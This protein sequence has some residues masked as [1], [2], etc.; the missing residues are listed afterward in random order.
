[1]PCEIVGPALCTRQKARHHSLTFAP[2]LGCKR[3]PRADTCHPPFGVEDMVVSSQCSVFLSERMFNVKIRSP[4]L[5]AKKD[6]FPNGR[7][8]EHRRRRLP[9]LAN[10][11]G[12]HLRGGRALTDHCLGRCQR[13][14]TARRAPRFGPRAGH[15][16]GRGADPRGDRH[17][18][19]ANRGWR[20]RH[21]RDDH[22]H[23]RRVPLRDAAPWLLPAGCLGHRVYQPR[24][25][26]RA[27]QKGRDPHSRCAPID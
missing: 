21:A 20:R 9:P 14:G 8:P 23:S 10:R 13:R 18:H 5:H 11:S 12:Q 19:P 27:R 22:R 15:A 3:S 1:M 6:R 4:S 2:T 17:G 24:A 25:C 16:L 7:C 26:H